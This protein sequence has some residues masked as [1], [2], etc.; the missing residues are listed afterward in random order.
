MARPSAPPPSSNSPRAQLLATEHWGLLAARGTA[1]SEVLTRI[2]IFLTLFSAGLVSI[3]LVGQATD[4]DGMFGPSA[5]AILAIVVIIGQLTQV[6]VLNVGIEDMMY[7]LA[8]NRMRAAYVELDPAIERYLMASTHDD[9]RGLSQTYDFFLTRSSASHM[10]G[11]SMVLIAV[12]NAI[13]LGL[14]TA[15]VSLTAGAPAW[16]TFTIGGVVAVGFAVFVAVRGQRDFMAH[17]R[18]FVPLNPTP[19]A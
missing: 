3:A 16:L 14:L 19:E 1:Q 4:F 13:L 17:W 18:R 11:S 5:I 12:V 2:T 8:M 6:R 15:S 10:I 9:Q 7:V